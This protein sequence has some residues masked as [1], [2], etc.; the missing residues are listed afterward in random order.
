VFFRFIYLSAFLG[1]I[2]SKVV[3]GGKRLSFCAETSTFLSC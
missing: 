1:V 2:C 3:G